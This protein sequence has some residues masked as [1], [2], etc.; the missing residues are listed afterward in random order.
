MNEKGGNVRVF[1]RVRPLLEQGPT[2][3]VDVSDRSIEVSNQRFTFDG[4]FDSDATQDDV[5]EGL[6]C[7]DLVRDVLSGYNGTVFA[8]GQTASGKSYT[9]DGSI[10]P[11]CA[12]ALFAGVAAADSKLEFTISVSFVEIYREKIRDLL[13][14]AGVM[15]LQIR[16]DPNTQGVYVSGCAAHFV[17]N[18]T[19]FMKTVEEGRKIR[20]TAATGMNVGS[21]RSHSVLEV[22]V[23]TTDVVSE[24]RRAGRLVLVD[25]AGSEMVKKSHA[26]G[27]QLEEAKTINKSLSALG[28]V[29]N[30]LTD[31]AKTHVPYRDSKLTRML[32]DSL[33]GN[34]KTL[35][36]VNVSAASSNASE[37][38][39][40][41]RFGKRAKFV[42]NTPRVNERKS[43]KELT[44]LLQKAE[45]AIDMQSA[46]I[47]ALEKKENAA[48]ATTQQQQQ[49]EDD[50]TASSAVLEL[51]K[52]LDEERTENDLRANR[53]NDLQALLKEKDGLLNESEQ[54]LKQAQEHLSSLETTL[55]ETERDRDRADF[56]VNQLTLELENA[57]KLKDFR[58]E[59]PPVD[60]VQDDDVGG[61]GGGTVDDLAELVAKYSHDQRALV[62]ALRRREGSGIH[63][64]DQR[65]RLVADLTL[66]TDRIAKLEAAISEGADAKSG[67]TT[68]SQH[69]MSL[70]QRLEQLVA[71]HRQLLRKYAA[72]ELNLG[73]AAKK[74]ALRDQ[75][76]V[77]LEKER[78]RP[79]SMIEQQQAVTAIQHKLDL[80]AKKHHVPLV[81]TLRGGGTTNN[82]NANNGN[83]AANWWSS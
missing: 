8:Y 7:G 25:L 47:A 44:A 38:V 2:R 56:Q 67:T 35:L 53:I 28:M 12:S 40:T 9:M 17:A 61:G 18:E 83:R 62:E 11:R 23:N 51:R 19:E 4:V 72:L 70:R 65:R 49:L 6:G 5:F 76:I 24:A 27:E 77:K 79:V 1:C 78:T 46:Y 64:D 57:N 36:I 75:R 41:L 16:E 13:D 74:I 10:V 30:A 20:A 37:T 32:Q 73:E 54:L 52:A 48:A 31:D 66:A 43:V 55:A 68:D 71:V 15:S 26:T 82:E 59:N 81:K 45:A 63:R 50:E 34:A 69:A 22:R 33:G 58:D 42:K 29:I 3:C 39:S 14:P 60:L 21:S 80:L